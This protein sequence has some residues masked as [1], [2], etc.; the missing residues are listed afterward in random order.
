MPPPPKPLR[1]QARFNRLLFAGDVM[2]SRGVR[3]QILLSGDPALPFRKI[4]PLLAGA[5]LAFVNLES[6][7]SDRGPY[8]EDGLIFHAPPAAI[9]GLQLAHVAV[10]STANN[11]SR[12]CGPYGVEFTINW[13]CSHGIAPVGSGASAA[14][15]HRGVILERNGVRFGFLGYTFDQQ[16]GNWRDID[17][18]IAAADLAVVSEDVKS[19]RK[20][21]DVVIVSIHNGIEYMI[22]PTRAQVEFAHAAIDA[23]A[24]LVIGHHP[25]VT[26]P[27]ETYR[28][29]LVFYSLGNCVFDQFQREATQHG[30][31][32]EVDYLG[33]GIFASNV[34]PVKITPSGPELE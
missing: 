9:A 22:R 18:R 17:K 19:L 25:H 33:P 14:Q 3:R 28:G 23:G 1:I 5:D 16:N 13:L 10:V 24:S 30:E 31:I 7:F 2:F 20:R 4:A 11:H 15:T 29:G 12:D 34:W 32:A 21:S 8:H 27:E 6:P 26:Q